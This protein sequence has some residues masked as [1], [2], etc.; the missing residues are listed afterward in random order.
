MAIYET[1]NKLANEI[2]NSK[3]YIQFKKYMREIKNDPESEKLLT[4]YKMS[5]AKIQN[6]ILNNPKDQKKI[7]NK[8]ESLQKKVVNNKKINRYL[9]SEQQF[10]AMMA[11]INQILAKAVEHDYK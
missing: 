3:E 11:N 10:T 6:F 7:L 8:L 4:E 1:A 2:K 9:N 5:Q